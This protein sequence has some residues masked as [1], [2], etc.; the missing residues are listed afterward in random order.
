M[1]EVYQRYELIKSP[2]KRPTPWTLIHIDF[3]D[4]SVY[5]IAY[6]YHEHTGKHV[7]ELLNKDYKLKVELEEQ[8]EKA[9]A[10]DPGGYDG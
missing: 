3:S 1:A 4:N 8:R 10:N 7:A 2:P 5:D 6:F 9:R